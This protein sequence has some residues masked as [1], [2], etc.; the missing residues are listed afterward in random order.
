MKYDPETMG[1][2]V[3][4]SCSSKILGLSD[5][6]LRRGIKE[7]RYPHIKRGQTYLLNMPLMIQ[8]LEAESRR[9]LE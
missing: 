8:Q 3:G 6:Q 4:L 7:K 1:I 5:Y 2:Y 9:S